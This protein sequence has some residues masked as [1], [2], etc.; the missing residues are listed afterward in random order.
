VR[1]KT[2]WNNKDK[3]RTIQDTASTLAFNTWRICQRALLNLENEGFQ[4]DTQADRLAV[5]KEFSTLLLHVIDRVA[6]QRMDDEERAAFVTAVAK[7]L[8]DYVQDNGRDLL[9][10]GDHRTPYI[11]LL[12]RRMDEF[13][14][15]GFSDFEP[16]F[17]MTRYFGDR[18]AETLGPRQREWVSTQIIDIEVPE[19]LKTL[20]RVMNSMVPELPPESADQP[21]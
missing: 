6:Y 17:Q 7:R 14:E 16:S 12:N 5:I 20:K 2:R 18:L 19:A 11:E 15:F 3:A 9:G 21:A 1:V 4:T 13:S 8:A 10:P